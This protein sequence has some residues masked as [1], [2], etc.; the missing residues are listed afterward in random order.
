MTPNMFIKDILKSL[1]GAS[2]ILHLSG[3]TI[4]RLQHFMAEIL[5]WL[6]LCFNTGT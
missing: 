1:S 4:V 2:A 6:L 5:S 3:P